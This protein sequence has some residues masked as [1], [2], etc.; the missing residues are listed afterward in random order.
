MPIPADC[1]TVGK[2]V[3]VF[4]I[5]GWLKL[6]S[7]T[8]PVENMMGYTPLWLERPD[9]ELEKVEFDQYRV[10]VGQ[11]VAHI[12]GVDDRDEAR[13]YCHRLV[14]VEK[15]CMPPLEPGCYYW[16]QLV[17]LKVF[18]RHH[19][20]KA[21]LGR[22]DDLIETGANLVMRVVPCEG[23][24]DQRERLLP[25]LKGHYGI[26]VDLVDGSLLIDWDPDF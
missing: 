23:S 19:P 10:Q 14:K 26:Q 24:V 20:Q 11:L 12:A 8:E 4:G 1:I 21:F 18:S 22:I 6:V 9:G 2:I 25:Y 13:A 3:A 7:Y 5:K 16:H 15:R 17:G